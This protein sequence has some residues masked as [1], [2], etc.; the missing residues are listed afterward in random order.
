MQIFFAELI[1]K[2]L[3]FNLAPKIIMISHYYYTVETLK[4]AANFAGWANL[5]VSTVLLACEMFLAPFL[6]T[7]ALQTM[8]YV[9]DLWAAQPH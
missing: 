5:P 4:V 8:K 6:K 2:S 7:V 1:A 3:N 9:S